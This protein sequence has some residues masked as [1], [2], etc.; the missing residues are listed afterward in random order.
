VWKFQVDMIDDKIK[1]T[2]TSQTNWTWAAFS[3]VAYRYFARPC[4][5]VWLGYCFGRESMMSYLQT[6]EQ[7][8]KALE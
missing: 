1:E 4:S 2:F 6:E 3:E 7:W 5:E 8:T